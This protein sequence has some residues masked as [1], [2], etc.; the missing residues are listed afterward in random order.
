MQVRLTAVLATAV[1]AGVPAWAAADGI[2]IL[3]DQ[4][5][6]PTLAHVSDAN[7]DSRHAT[8]GS[9][10]AASDHMD[11]V[12]VADTGTSSGTS[13]SQLDSSYADPAHMN[14]TGAATV[15][16]SSLGTADMSADAQYAVTFFL[17][18]TYDYVFS[19]QFDINGQSEGTDQFGNTQAF[20]NAILSRG[21]ATVFSA[22]DLVNRGDEPSS[23]SFVGTLGP[24]TYSLNVQSASTALWSQNLG[25]DGFAASTFAFTFDLSAQ[26]PDA[27][28]S[29]TPEPA[30]LLLLGSGAVGLLRRYRR[31][32]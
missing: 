27:G 8:G 1:L 10:P 26:D 5:Q 29:P 15:R 25:S 16:W 19:G 7:G 18:S 28:G 4:R 31:R 3:N 17:P 9:P 23:R 21:G 11:A 2:T 32:S 30:S 12:E 6:V 24:G 22:S 13:H 20:W 14:G